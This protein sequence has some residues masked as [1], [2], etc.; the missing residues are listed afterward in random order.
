MSARVRRTFRPRLEILEDR[1][2]PAL[3]TVTSNLDDNG[4][5]LTL[6]EALVLSNATPLVTDTIVFK[7]GLTSP[8]TLTLGQLDIEDDVIIAG[9]GASKITISGNNSLR[10][11]DVDD[12]TGSVILVTIKGLKLTNGLA[13]GGGAIRNTGE[14][15]TI[16][17]CVIANN[18]ASGGGGGGLLMVGGVL[19]IRSSH[20]SGNRANT[21]DGGGLFVD[22]TD[23]G[24]V[25]IT[26]STFTT[27]IATSGG[28]GGR[29]G[30]IFINVG[31]S[32]AVSIVKT[33]ISGNSAS[34][35]GGLRVS[36]AT[37]AVTIK[38]CTISG[39]NAE[40]AGGVDVSAAGQILI[41]NSTIAGNTSG[42]SGGG[43]AI[44]NG[45][46][47]IVRNST[48]S[49][50]S[51][52]TDGGGIH[53][54]TSGVLTVQNS[55]IAFNTAGDQGGGIYNETSV[56]MQSTIVA[57]NDAVTAG[58]ELFSLAT[59]DLFTIDHCLIL[60]I[61]GAS[62]VESQPGTNV[63][64]L[65]PLLGPLAFNGGPTPTHALGKGSAA[66][67]KGSN[68]AFQPFDQRGTPFKRK[69][70]AAVDIGAFER[71]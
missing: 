11:F 71:Q 17:N 25:N 41:L 15:L 63:F 53:V 28:G 64:G 39:N 58:D 51:A 35:G 24:G 55:T 32:D 49:N 34:A 36:G 70:G 47:I 29:G 54:D 3:L 19:T 57:K 27:N 43:I 45:T 65:D 66:L 52:T 26:S 21:S 42:T 60:G 40:G 67:N 4:A 8:I 69:L 6:R 5:G 38:Q 12:N 18:V 1:C 44:L 10:I 9:P 56:V 59:D 16:K 33:T 14:N 23:P 48:I 7:A 20:F 62:L 61:A 50:N 2:V 46:N 30:G 31:V 22:S 68:P 13:F 37:G